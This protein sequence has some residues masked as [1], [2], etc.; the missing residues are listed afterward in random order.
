MQSTSPQEAADGYLHFLDDACLCATTHVGATGVRP[1]AGYVSR[2]RGSGGDRWLEQGRWTMRDYS[3][4]KVVAEHVRYL[5]PDGHKTYVWRRNGSKGLKGLPEASL[6]LYGG[7]AWLQQSLA[8]CER[9]IFVEGEKAAD[10]LLGIGLPAVGIPLGA[11]KL[12][13]LDMFEP[14]R[15][16]RLL[17][18]PDADDVGEQLLDRLGDLLSGAGL[19]LEVIRWPQAPPKGDAAD[20]RAAGGTADQAEALIARAEAWRPQ[21]GAIV[22]RHER[23]VQFVEERRAWAAWEQTDD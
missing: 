15:G 11:P 7:Y 1:D 14:F 13:D 22:Y 12:P 20:F 3:T 9:V 17:M 8:D 10:A 18:W 4:G 2:T 19:S 6:P 16:A 5:T 21:G 23:L